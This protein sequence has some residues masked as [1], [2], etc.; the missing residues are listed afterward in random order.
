MSLCKGWLSFRNFREKG[1]RSD[2]SHKNGGAGKIGGV[3]SKKWGDGY[4]LFS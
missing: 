1:R 3:V 4:H 2:L